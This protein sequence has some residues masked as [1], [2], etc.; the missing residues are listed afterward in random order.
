MLRSGFIIF[1]IILICIP[2]YAQVTTTPVHEQIG[3]YTIGPYV[4]PLNSSEQN[5]TYTGGATNTLTFWDLPLWIQIACIA[6]FLIALFTS[7]KLIPILL[8]KLSTLNKN[9]RAKRVEKYVMEH[10]GCTMTQISEETDIQ[11]D[12]VKYYVYQF[13]TMGKLVLERAGR[14]SLLYNK[15]IKYDVFEKSVVS[16]LH[17]DTNRK[18]LWSIIENPGITSA[19]LSTKFG[20]SKSTV[21]WYVTK[22]LKD[23]LITYNKQGNFKKYFVNAEVEQILRKYYGQT[24]PL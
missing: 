20:L 5:L 10:P 6:E 9:K 15:S 2:A 7:I 16:H 13:I 19:D 11:R 18:I 24:V 23:S 17:D 3:K 8:G 14:Y 4:P 1:L 21:S 22:L 12:T